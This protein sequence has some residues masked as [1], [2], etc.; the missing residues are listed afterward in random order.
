LLAEP[1]M[2]DYVLHEPAAPWM[3]RRPDAERSETNALEK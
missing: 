3:P 1:A 2:A